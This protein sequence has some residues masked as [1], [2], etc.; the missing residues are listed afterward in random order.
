MPH[1]S[2]VVLFAIIALFVSWL[3]SPPDPL[4]FL[5]DTTA[6]FVVTILGYYIALRKG[7]GN[8]TA[9]DPKESSSRS[10]WEFTI[11]EM[12]LA[13]LACALL[14]GLII[15]DRP[16]IPTPFFAALHNGSTDPIQ[17]V[18]KRLNVPGNGS[19]GGS[20]NWGKKN[21]RIQRSFAMNSIEGAEAWRLMAE[22]KQEIKSLL[23]HHGCC[24]LLPTGKTQYLNETDFG[25]EYE[26]STTRGE[27][28]VHSLIGSEKTWKLLILIGETPK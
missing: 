27:I 20:S 19:G 10:R 18:Y 21:A 3:I 4:S 17:S 7:Q 8:V 28:Q 16:F 24:I 9:T 26:T 13:T 23:H 25:F 11:R 14:M 6:L 12:L 15:K 1:P 22:L 2:T 5:V